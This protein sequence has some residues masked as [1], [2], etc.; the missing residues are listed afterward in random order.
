MI[1]INWTKEID[2]VIYQM[3]LVE[4]R[5]KNYLVKFSAAPS[6]VDTGEDDA[7][8]PCLVEL[9]SSE[10]NLCNIYPKETYMFIKRSTDGFTCY[11]VDFHHDRSIDPEYEH[12]SRNIRP[13]Y[14]VDG[15]MDKIRKKP[16]EHDTNGCVVNTQ[17]C[18]VRYRYFAKN[19]KAVFDFAEDI[20]NKTVNDIRLWEEENCYE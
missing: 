17:S 14:S 11:A 15:Y 12:V 20:Y 16:I 8:S 3:E 13:I 9:S 10:I 2:D 18:V 19:K 4:I 7:S 1:K 6:D 5:D